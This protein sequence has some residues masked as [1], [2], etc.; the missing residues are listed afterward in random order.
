MT[1]S[2]GSPP[3]ARYS[4]SRIEDASQSR[5]DGKIGFLFRPK[6]PHVLR[7]RLADEFSEA[8]HHSHTPH[9]CGNVRRAASITHDRILYHAICLS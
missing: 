6:S 4:R 3:F 5:E 7:L 1:F 2:H 9:P 8:S